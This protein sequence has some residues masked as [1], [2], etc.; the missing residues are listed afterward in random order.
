MRLRDP[1]PEL[2][3]AL[4]W[5]NGEETDH[6]SIEKRPI[7]IHFWSVS[8]HLCKVAMPKVN[9]LRD[10]FKEDMTVLSIHMPRVEGDYDIDVVKKV[11]LE[12][13]IAQPILL[14][15]HHILKEKFQNQYVPSYY[16]FDEKGVLRHYQ[17]GGS[18][19]SMVESRINRLLA[20]RE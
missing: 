12:H 14:D 3:G 15:Q 16:L 4:M 17:A 20:E 6:N 5:L 1:I 19:M 9:E 10:K 2:S 11:A 8:C 13:D 7:F 18:S